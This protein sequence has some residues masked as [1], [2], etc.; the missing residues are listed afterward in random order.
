MNH[1]GLMI[2]R[3]RNLAV[4][5]ALALAMAGCH[6]YVLTTP[7]VSFP[8]GPDAVA[9]KVLPA[10]PPKYLMGIYHVSKGTL[11]KGRVVDIRVRS[12][13]GSFPVRVC[14]SAEDRV[15]EVRIPY[16]PHSRG[17][18]IMGDAFLLQFLDRDASEMEA[19]PVDAVSGATVSSRAVYTAVKRAL[20][21]P[22]PQEDREVQ[23]PLGTR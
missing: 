10:A 23:D 11:S 17:R 7:D 22:L 5:G 15:L 14:I 1:S 12:R 3:A 6:S 8:Y 2:K 20:Y 13:S 9:T 16:Y 19:T 4:V 18:G 21:L